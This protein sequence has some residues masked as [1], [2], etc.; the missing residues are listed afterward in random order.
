MGTQ[1][2]EMSW[3]DASQ[4]TCASPGVPPLTTL[5]TNTAPFGVAAEYSV[6]SA[7]SFMGTNRSSPRASG[8]IN[9]TDAIF[10]RLFPALGQEGSYVVPKGPCIETYWCRTLVLTRPVELSRYSYE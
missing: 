8:L 3:E 5:S 4:I 2:C 7:P 6:W 1:G 9:W 10:R